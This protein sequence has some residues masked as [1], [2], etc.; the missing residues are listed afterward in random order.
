[1]HHCQPI[2]GKDP[3]VNITTRKLSLSRNLSLMCRQAGCDWTV[4]NGVIMIATPGSGEE[5]QTQIIPISS[6]TSRR[7]AASQGVIR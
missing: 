4:E 1:M 2:E 6:T 5:L 7:L 3:T